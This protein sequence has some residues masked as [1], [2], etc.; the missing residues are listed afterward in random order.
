MQIELDPSDHE[1]PTW[2]VRT[3]EAARKQ[4]RFNRRTRMILCVAAVAAVVVN[5]GAAWAYWQITG[6]RVAST[7]GGENVEMVL[8]ARSDLTNP[9]QRGATG[10]LTVTVT[11]DNDYPIRIT[12]ITGAGPITA[13]EEHQRAGCTVTGVELTQPTFPV[14]WEVNRNTIGAFEVEGGLHMRPNVKKACD[15]VTFTVP[16]RASGVRHRTD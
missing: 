11:N 5:A 4:R 3:P 8:R 7:A 6:S 16:V 14:R 1:E 9:L 15:G 12:S 10:D 13:D 2:E